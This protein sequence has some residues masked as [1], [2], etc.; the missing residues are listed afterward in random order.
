MHFISRIFW[1]TCLFTI[2]ASAAVTEGRPSRIIYPARVTIRMPLEPPI[3]V[4]SPEEKIHQEFTQLR[5]WVIENNL[6]YFHLANS[7]KTVLSQILDEDENIDQEAKRSRTQAWLKSVD[8]L[9][10]NP[11]LFTDKSA[12]SKNF[13]NKFFT[14]LQLALRL[15]PSEDLI[16]TKQMIIKAL[17][18]K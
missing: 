11:I 8:K 16:Q 14:E 2:S 18:G 3:S 13:R 1:L 15:L 7:L 12:T 9:L 4:I 17:T 10:H 6:T 5:N